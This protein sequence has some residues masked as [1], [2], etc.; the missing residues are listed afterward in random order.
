VTQ[1]T[2]AGL[3]HKQQYLSEIARIINQLHADGIPSLSLLEAG[4][5]AGNTAMATLALLSPEDTFTAVDL[6]P[7]NLAQL[8]IRVEEARVRPTVHYHP[9]D[10]AR[11]TLLPDQTF[12]LVT[13][14]TLLNMLGNHFHLALAEFFRVLRPGGALCLRELLP[15]DPLQSNRRDLFFKTILAARALGSQPYTML[16]ID[17]IKATLH[18]IGFTNIKSLIVNAQPAGAGLDPSDLPHWYPLSDP[19]HPL[20]D[21]LIAHYTHQSQSAPDAGQTAFD[22]Y[23]IVCTR[24]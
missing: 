2:T 23:H 17:L 10:A 16:P 15:L 24:P 1:Q 12:N 3:T 20:R 7:A 14:D 4:I 8:Q 22:S 19:S 9:G 6:A 18:G 11:L 21:H 13:S 5:G